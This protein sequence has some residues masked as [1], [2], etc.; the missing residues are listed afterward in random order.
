ME[1]YY[2]RIPNPKELDAQKEHEILKKDV[3][4][5]LCLFLRQGLAYEGIKPVE[6]I[7]DIKID[8]ADELGIVSSDRRIFL[9]LLDLLA[10]VNN[11]VDNSL[12]KDVLENNRK[13]TS[14]GVQRE[15]VRSRAKEIINSILNDIG[16]SN[17]SLILDSWSGIL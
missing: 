16:D 7:W 5:S 8:T 13:I 6:N 11:D 12:M 1:K 4:D 3:V 9:A 15:I 10:K 17:F 2:K 14:Q